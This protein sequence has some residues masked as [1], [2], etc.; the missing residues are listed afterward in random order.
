MMAK[1]FQNVT[2]QNKAYHPDALK[3][4]YDIS[5]LPLITEP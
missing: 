2:I 1:Q 3:G 5:I 4:G